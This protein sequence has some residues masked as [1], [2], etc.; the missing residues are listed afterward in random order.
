M[1]VLGGDEDDV[2]VVDRVGRADET[3]GG[4]DAFLEGLLV[5][6]EVQFDSAEDPAA[7]G[8][9]LGGVEFLELPCH[10]SLAEIDGGEQGLEDLV[11]VGSP[12]TR[13]MSIVSIC[14]QKGKPRSAITIMLV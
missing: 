7:F 5:I 8:N 11:T 2:G 1:R 12:S 6:L 3:D 13:E 9:D 4:G 14:G 10:V